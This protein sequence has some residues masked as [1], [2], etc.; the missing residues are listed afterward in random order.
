MILPTYD[1]GAVANLKYSG[2]AVESRCPF[3]RGTVSLYYQS[4]QNCGRWYVIC[5][6]CRVV[7]GPWSSW[8]I[9]LK[10]WRIRL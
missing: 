8:V 9:A 2:R 3:C 6:P 5:H 1:A 7:M 4:P 10:N